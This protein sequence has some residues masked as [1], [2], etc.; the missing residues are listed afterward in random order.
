M[1]VY[2]DGSALNPF[3]I[4]DITLHPSRV[5]IAPHRLFP[6]FV[7]VDGSEE[8]DA[9]RMFLLSAEMQLG[10]AEQLRAAAEQWDE[11]GVCFSPDATHPDI[12]DAV[13]QGIESGR[14]L[15]VLFRLDERQ[16]VTV[17]DLRAAGVDKKLPPLPPG[18]NVA[19]M[20]FSQKL[21]RCCEM[22]PD[23]IGEKLG[24]RAKQEI[25]GFF[26]VENLAITAGI[27]AV[28]AGSHAVGVGFIV[29]GALLAV[30]F[31]FAGWEAIKAFEKIGEFFHEV[32]AASSERDLQIAAGLLASAIAILGIAGFKALL[33]KVTPKS[34]KGRGG[35]QT[36]DSGGGSGGN[37]GGSGGDTS[38]RRGDRRTRRDRD[39]DAPKEKPDEPPPKPKPTFDFSQIND[40]ISDQAQYRHVKGRKEWE[41][42]GKG[43]YF[44]N[45]EDAQSVL[46]AAKEGRV[47]VL[48]T[49]GQGQP[50]V[51]FKGVTGYNNNPRAGY[52]NQETNVFTIKGTKKVSVVPI[53]PNWSG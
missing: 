11:I 39:D 53:N 10:A 20:S 4:C 32:Y 24:A 15:G 35:G 31:F 19:G 28:W 29:D 43:G 41:A 37:R 9:I 34:P 47:E 44:N 5:L 25:E 50:V 22:V 12:V 33:R 49:N 17:S 2:L 52:M 8:P 18:G 3:E 48:G 40:R 26:S 42:R 1:P 13:M 51:R 21:M 23:Q 36:G 27:L 6:T 45:K 38:P 14:L 16:E 30:G 46:T 7:E